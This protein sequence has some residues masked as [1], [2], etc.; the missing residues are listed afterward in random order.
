[1][2][3]ILFFGT[4]LSVLLIVGCDKIEDPYKGIRVT[5]CGGEIN[6]KDNDTSYNDPTVK[7]RKLLCEEYTGHQ[8]GNCPKNSKKLID[9]SDNELAG[10]LVV[11]S[12]HAGGFAEI[13][14]R[15][16]YVLELRSPASYDL[17]DK[18]KGGNSAPSLMLN[19]SNSAP[20]PPGKW[21]S[22]IDSVTNSSYFDQP[23]LNFMIRNVY[24]APARSGN[25]TIKTTFMQAMSNTNL[26]VSVYISE[27]KV[28]GKQTDYSIAEEYKDDYEHRYVLRGSATPT[29]GLGLVTG[30][31]AVEQQAE[32]EVCYQI[33]PNW[34]EANCSLVI[35]VS[36]ANTNQIIQVEEMPVI[37]E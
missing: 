11:L 22:T 4:L 6:V 14:E 21:K 30:D 7:V 10:K 24:N 36:D 20:L 5:T 32:K 34:N 35:I 17:Q 29:F 9:W 8:C 12:V 18:Y 37:K 1:M 31:I 3:K 25:L 2:K 16:G 26:A 15:D 19:R 23:A 13:N 28:I 33:D 27:D